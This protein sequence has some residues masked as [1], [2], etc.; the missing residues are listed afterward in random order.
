M[1]SKKCSTRVC[2]FS[3]FA[4]TYRS[5]RRSVRAKNR[6]LQ[7]FRIRRRAENGVNICS[8]S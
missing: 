8:K 3:V 1:G 6:H 7:E 4:C 5:N 2:L